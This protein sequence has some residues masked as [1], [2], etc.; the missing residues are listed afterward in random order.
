MEKFGEAS[1]LRTNLQKRC[2]ISI[3]C[4]YQAIDRVSMTLPCTLAEFP[5]TYLGLPNSDKKLRKS[6]LLP[7]IEKIG[8]KLPGSKAVLMNMAGR[9]TVVWFILSAIP[10]YVL[11]AIKG[12]E[13]VRQGNG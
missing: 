12:T 11:I 8:D 5:C 6:S 7:W 3:R 9:A 4:E 13:M 2:V 1:R 10:V